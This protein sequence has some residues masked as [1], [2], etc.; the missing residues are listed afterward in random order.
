MSVFIF[1]EIQHKEVKI[2]FFLVQ[3]VIA[4]GI[5]AQHGVCNALVQLPRGF[6]SYGLI[7]FAAYDKR[8][9]LDS[10]QL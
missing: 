5:H 9:G 7:L 10:R 6:A 8:R 4:I 3:S 2:L 1:E